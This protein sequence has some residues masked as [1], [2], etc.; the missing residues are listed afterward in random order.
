M[1]LIAQQPKGRCVCG[2]EPRSRSVGRCFVEKSVRQLVPPICWDF[3]ADWGGGGGWLFDS[4]Y[5]GGEV[6]EKPIS[7]FAAPPYRSLPLRAVAC[8]SAPTRRG[9]LNLPPRCALTSNYRPTTA[10]P[11]PPPPCPSNAL[12]NELFRWV[13]MFFGPYQL[14]TGFGYCTACPTNSAVRT[15]FLEA[16]IVRCTRGAMGWEDP[17][18]VSTTCQAGGQTGPM[19][20]WPVLLAAPHWTRSHTNLHRPSPRP[21]Q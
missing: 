20:R 13:R 9:S 15:V 16:F 7:G 6:L 14:G 5:T 19:H 2:L 17:R 4:L 21:P 3:L 11:P 8:S 18:S 10:A 12:S 1:T